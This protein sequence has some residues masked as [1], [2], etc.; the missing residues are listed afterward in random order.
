M[1]HPIRQDPIVILSSR[2][3]ANREFSDDRSSKD[4]ERVTKMVM[5]MVKNGN[6]NANGNGIG[7]GYGDDS[8]KCNG[9]N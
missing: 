9:K 5:A 3:Y 6:G 8:Y 4:D 7:D 2:T 1:K